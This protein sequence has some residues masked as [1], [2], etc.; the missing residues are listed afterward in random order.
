MIAR[1]LRNDSDGSQVAMLRDHL[2]H[3]S[4]TEQGNAV[5]IL[6]RVR[7]AGFTEDLRVVLR[8]P[9]RNG[10]VIRQAAVAAADLN[11]TDLIDDIVDAMLKTSDSLIHQDCSIALKTLTPDGHLLEVSK[12]LIAA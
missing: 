8:D 7:P 3:G 6:A 11:L 2:R 9:D 1:L 4:E 5:R 12:R 10:V